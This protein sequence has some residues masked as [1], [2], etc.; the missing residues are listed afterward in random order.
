MGQSLSCWTIRFC[1][2]GQGVG[3]GLWRLRTES[4]QTTRRAWIEEILL[5][6]A[7]ATWLTKVPPSPILQQY[8]RPPNPLLINHTGEVLAGLQAQ[9]E[10]LP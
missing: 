8:P 4:R 10:L 3:V 5:S 9:P 6:L 7:R 1:E 2:S